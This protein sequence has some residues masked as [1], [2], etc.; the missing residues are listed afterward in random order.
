MPSATSYWSRSSGMNLRNLLTL[1]KSQRET[2]LTGLSSLVLRLA[3]LLCTFGLGVVLARA[4]G[5]A[6]FG[7]YG[8]V[9]SIAALG[10]TV[11]LLGTPQLAVRELSVRSARGDW[12]GVKALIRRFGLASAGAGLLMGALALGI[13][14]FIST[15]GDGAPLYLFLGA[16]LTLTT[17]V[18]AL[19][20]AELRGLG[21][22]LKGQFM[23]IAGRP[24]AAFLICL[25]IVLAGAPLGA[26]DA[27]WIQVAVSAAAAAIS[28]VWIRSI[29]PVEARSMGATG[30]IAWVGAAAPLWLVDVLRQVDGTYGVIL[31][32]WFASPEELGIYRVAFSCMMVVAMPVSVL[33]I[34]QA[35]AVSKLYK[36]GEHEALQRL[37]SETS[38]WMV[39]LVAPITL[40]A[41]LIGRPAITL[42]FG[43]AY[44]DAWLPLFIL[45]LAQLVFGVFGMGPILLAMCDGERH[46]IK[47]YVVSVGLAVLAAIPLVMAFVPRALQPP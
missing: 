34:I 4:L 43:A 29:L 42:V 12:G 15:P 22:M 35:P 38:S 40:A 37:L 2:V 21:A 6:G 41:W 3:G 16:L 18:T 24:A 46:L 45:C 17:T 27:L 11:S 10:M 36:F 9:V 5:P 20:A 26:V 47:L 23:D 30:Q 7:I 13:G 25:A 39:L 31:M 19:I 8:L 14:S 44:S 32:G 28:L 33:H 1:A